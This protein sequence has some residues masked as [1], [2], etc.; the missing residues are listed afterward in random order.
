MQVARAAGT[1]KEAGAGIVLH[2]KLGEAVPRDGVLFEVYAERPS[3]LEAALE[4]ARKLEPVVLSR[5]PEERMLLDQYP[6]KIGERDKVVTL[7]R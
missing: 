5:K 1:P 3:K 2:A 6:A 4:L 7:D